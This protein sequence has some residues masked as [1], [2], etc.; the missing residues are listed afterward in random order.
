[1]A[2]EK[3]TLSEYEVAEDMC[4]DGLKIVQD[5]RLYR[6]TSDSVLLSK[7]AKPKKGDDVAD[8]CAG[9]GIVGFHFYALHKEKYPDLRFTLFELQPELTALSQKTAK[10]NGFENFDFVNG[11]L[12]DLPKQFN[13]RFSLI[14]CNPPYERGG[15]ENGE[16]RIVPG[17]QYFINVGSVGQPRDGDPRAS[18]VVFDTA[19]RVV[20]F[21]RLAYDVAAAQVRVSSCRFST[22]ASC[23]MPRSRFSFMNS[24]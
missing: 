17:K 18:Y 12:Q 8:F 2:E 9:S 1:M 22:A 10:L 24:A 15:F 16:F 13:E 4:M 21:R 3:V 14:L 6:F 7:F 20:R 19:S 11:R 23:G 5:T